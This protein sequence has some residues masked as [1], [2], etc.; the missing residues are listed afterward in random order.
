MSK[1]SNTNSKVVQL[2]KKIKLNSAVIIFF[3]ILIYVVGNVIKS[4]TKDTYT[5]YQVN[6]SN[7][8]NNISC[9][10]IALRKETSVKSTKTG[11]V[12]YFA[13]D[14]DKVSLG[15]NVCSVDETGNIIKSIQSDKD[16]SN[17]ASLTDADYAEIRSTIDTYKSAYT[18][19]TFGEVYNFKDQIES[20]VL[21]ISSEAMGN[22][23]NQSDSSVSSTLENIVS[24]DS[25]VIAYYTDGFESKTSENLTADDFLKSQYKR[26]T[27]KSGTMQTA[28]STVFKLCSDENWQIVCLLDKSQA[29]TLLEENSIDF[30]IN[31]SPE[32]IKGATYNI[33]TLPSDKDHSLLV[34]NLDKYMVDYIDD[35][36]FNIDIIMNQYEGLKVPN[37]SIVEK[38][39]YKIP[40]GNVATSTDASTLSLNI[41]RTD[42][43]G[44]QS[45]QKLDVHIDK[46]DSGYYYVDSSEFKDTDFLV[47]DNDSQS[48]PVISLEFENVK[49]VYLANQGIADFKE[50][51]VKKTE[52][53]FTIIDDGGNLKEY[54]SIV[55]NAKSVTADQSL[56]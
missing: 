9:T 14:G 56:N 43:N 5:I 18:D 28:G 41:L 25:G 44:K 20:N 4:A 30:K 38:K 34:L 47:Q 53:E 52:D 24:P 46:Q 40:I 19:E 45:P 51:N 29:N 26:A 37:D 39:L 31:N 21:A 55:Q 7:I 1:I 35:R 36:F 32:A 13:K 3:I 27:I 6:S 33:I 17:T 48:V 2:N 42:K 10:G 16:G 50:V 54:D 11:Y 8:N 15:E 22:I 23:V 49:G 12:I